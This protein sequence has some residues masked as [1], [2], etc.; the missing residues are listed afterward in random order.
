MS[1]RRALAPRSIHL[2]IVPRPANLSESREIFRVLQR[3]G[4]ISTFKYL[5]YEYQNPAD[6]VAL[7][8]YSD[9]ASAQRALDASPIRFAL[10]KVISPES[11]TNTPVTPT[12]DEDE[13]IIST[14]SQ[15]PPKQGI[16]EILRPSKLLN[17]TST[18]T[19]NTKP[20]PTPP[21]MPF[22]PLSPRIQKKSTKW[23]QVTIDRSRAVHQDYIERQPFWKQFHPMKSMAQLD[24]AKSVPHIGLSD[25]S[26]RPPNA[27]RTPNRVLKTM[28]EYVQ[29]RM[30]TL[31]QIVEGGERERQFVERR[32]GRS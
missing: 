21:P 16:D 20:A 4:E 3:F 7:A 12:E 29:T 22:E 8:I 15:T 1:V 25:V 27:H 30:P 14:T 32:A 5:R 11:E 19:R 23:F 24:L 13:D 28:N 6:N 2:R 26:K 9:Q 17:R 18:T 10:E 31:R